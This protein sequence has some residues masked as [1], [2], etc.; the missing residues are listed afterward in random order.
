MREEVLNANFKNILISLNVDH[1]KEQA[2]ALAKNMKMADD[3]NSQIN[4][5]ER[6]TFIHI[7]MA[8]VYTQ[9]T[10]LCTFI[11]P[12]FNRDKKFTLLT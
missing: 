2:T 9:S 1:D 12:V 8:L 7:H 10:Y 6:Y 3:Y 11:S 4:G 5:L